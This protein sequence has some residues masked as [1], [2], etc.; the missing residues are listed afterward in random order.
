MKNFWI[1]LMLALM[2]AGCAQTTV[3]ESRTLDLPGFTSVESKG[4]LRVRIDQGPASVR[5]ESGPDFHAYIQTLVNDS[6]LFVDVPETY[7]RKVKKTTLYITLPEL[8]HVRNSGAGNLEVSLRKASGLKVFN[9]GAGNLKV[10]FEGDS[11]ECCNSGIG[12]VTLQGRAGTARLQNHGAGLIASRG[13]EA[14]DVVV[15]NSGAGG[16][17]VSSSGSL[18]VVNKGIGVV[19]YTGP[20][21]LKS[22]MSQGL[23]KVKRMKNN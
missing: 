18:S 16:V 3:L 1:F 8:R 20:G 9:D 17:D 4:T 2:G 19:R 21:E 15:E 22:V 11:L 13:L 5:L 12:M 7:F 10:Q 23:G 14:R 6:V